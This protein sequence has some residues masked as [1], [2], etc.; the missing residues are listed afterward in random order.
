MPANHQPY[1]RI[2]N[3]NTI[4][5]FVHGIQGSPIQFRYMISVIPKHIDYM[6][7]LLPGH[8]ET[9]HSFRSVGKKEWTT[10]FQSLCHEL[11]KEYNN[12]YFVGHSLGCLIGIDAACSDD[13]KFSGM[14]LLACPLRIRLSMRY[15]RTCYQ[16]IRD[17]NPS[18]VYVKAAKDAN[19][20]FFR[21]PFELI[22]CPKP[23]VGLLLMILQSRHKFKHMTENVCMIHSEKDEIVSK[24]SINYIR[25]MPNG[26]VVIL[27]ESGHFYYAPS[28][29]KIIL[30]ELTELLNKS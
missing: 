19:S 2:S 18:S 7:I 6:C 4:V 16:A 9:I 15:I 1:S 27:P 5:L 23:Y 12:I 30:Q 17:K 8:G 11:Q 13:V 10:Y 21:S 3:A 26:R 14:L 20:V 25:S 24:T 28:A 29:Q 22:T